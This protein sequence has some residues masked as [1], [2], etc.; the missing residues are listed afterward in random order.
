MK[1]EFDIVVL[2]AGASGM[3]AELSAHENGSSVG[4]FEKQSLIGGTAGI[5]G[6]IIWAPMNS[7]MKKAGIDDD[8]SKSIE[9]FM[10]LSQGD[11][12][13]PLLEAFIDNCGEALDF[14]EEKTDA[15]FSI[16]D[17]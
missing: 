10:S 5:S 11:I 12:N 14:L 7:H 2:G 9:Y 6:G 17:C 16:L 15:K 13:Q 4:I 3:M 1:K 8:R